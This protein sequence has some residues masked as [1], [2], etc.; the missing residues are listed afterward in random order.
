VQ[1]VREVLVFGTSASVL[2]RQHRQFRPIGGRGGH[3]SIPGF[4]AGHVDGDRRQ[5][6]RSHH[7]HRT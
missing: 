7:N 5:G 1:P 6:N 2:E 4:P 3:C